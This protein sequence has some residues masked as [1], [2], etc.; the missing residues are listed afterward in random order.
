M[1]ANEICTRVGM[2]MADMHLDMPMVIIMK[3]ND[4]FALFQISTWILLKYFSTIFC[5]EKNN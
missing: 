3:K 2:D 5:D 1:L 4:E